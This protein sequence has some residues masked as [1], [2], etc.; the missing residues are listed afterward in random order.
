MGF[1]KPPPSEPG[2]GVFA[3]N[4]DGLIAENPFHKRIAKIQSKNSI[5]IDMATIEKVKPKALARLR[6]ANKDRSRVLIKS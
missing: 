3:K 6:L 4:N 5:P 2:A 1:A